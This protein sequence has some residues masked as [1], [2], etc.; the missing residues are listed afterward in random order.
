[1]RTFMILFCLILISLTL[2]SE[3]KQHI[4]SIKT[5]R[6]GEIILESGKI[7]KSLLTTSVNDFQYY[8]IQKTD[9]SSIS[10]L[11]KYIPS[12]L[13]QTNSRG[14]TLL[15]LRGSGERQL[16]LFFDGVLL[17]VPWDN[18]MD[19]SIL[20]VDIVGRV[21]VNK[22]SSSILFGPNIL[23]GALNI[24]T[25]ERQ[26]D[27]FGAVIRLQG[28][29][30][31]SQLVSL[32]HD[33]RIGNFNY[34]T[35]LSYSKSDGFLLPSEE[36][37]G[38]S[39]NQNQNSGLRTNTD[40]NRLTA[41]IRGEY[42]IDGVAT[43]GLSFNHINTE[44]G[45]ATLTEAASSDIRYW[46]YPEIIRDILTL[47]GEYLIDENINIKAV[48]WLDKFGQTINS[49]SNISLSELTQKQIDDD[50]TLGTRISLNYQLLE[51][52]N[53]IL[54]F[55]GFRSE[56][57]E[58]IE[59]IKSNINNN[60]YLQI[61]MSSGIEYRG[62]I[63][64]LLLLGGIAYDYNKNPLTGVFI[65]YEG[66]SSSDYAAFLGL[67]YLL[68]D[69]IDFYINSS[70]RTRFPTMRES[71]SGAMNKFKV[72]PDLKPESGII[73]EFGMIYHEEEFTFEL[74]GFASF[75]DD[76][77]DQIRLSQDEDFLERKMRVNFSNA[78]IS[79]VEA[80]FKYNPANSLFF[81]GYLTYMYSSGEN[82]GKTLKHLEY[83]PELMGLINFG[84]KFNNGLT[85]NFEFECV[86][87]QWGAEP[88]GELR[89]LEA[90]YLL[91]FRLSY[92]FF[93]DNV[94]SEIYLR[95]NNLLDKFSVS[96]IGLPNPGRMVY[97]GLIIRI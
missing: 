68:N 43:F 48:F 65:D 36:I 79:G 59:D 80:Q 82:D 38:D 27:G 29:D 2:W 4:D 10:D 9:A 13:I 1:M 54:A 40:M 92:N 33:G 66:L 67:R 11:G 25:I 57:T 26:N 87:T 91:N 69:E 95:C 22:G 55:N 64:D 86:G 96:K 18:R 3:E 45:V 23:G 44:K 39:T 74:T 34:I 35:N 53:L 42:K 52:H 61:T 30:A 97:G 14:E 78:T 88:K 12:G 77:I 21:F 58:E 7:N 84:Y 28:N 63:G 72:N 16:G 15:F 17:N 94:Y 49:Y 89:E 51:N 60:V 19:L 81:E 73:N 50:L 56:H 8:R 41:Y 46:R 5:Y 32:M 20:P 90:Y 6:L 47:N 83:K 76:L 24:S 75:Y 70:R 62:R 71:F 37:T 93:V 31:N 85:P